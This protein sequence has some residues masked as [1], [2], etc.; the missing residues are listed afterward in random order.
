MELVVVFEFHV[1]NLAKKILM[2]DQ[3]FAHSD[4]S[5]HNRYVH[6]QRSFA[7]ENRRQHRHSL[8]GEGIRFEPAQT[9]FIRYHI[10]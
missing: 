7:G 8:L 2:V 9:P 5:A 6:L 4:E 3:H 10:L 1:L